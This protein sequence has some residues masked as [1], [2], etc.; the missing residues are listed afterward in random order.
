METC[1]ALTTLQDAG[2]ANV[3]IFFN[4]YRELESNYCTMLEKQLTA[5]HTQVSALHPFTS[6]METFFFASLYQGRV[7]DGILQY[8][9]YFEVCRQ[10]SIPRVVFHGDYVQ[11]PYPFAKHCE[12]YLRLRTLAREYGVEFCQ[13]NVVRCKCGTP[14]FI[15]K[16][17]ELTDDDVSFVLDVKQMRRANVKTEEMLHAMAGK[18]SHVHLSDETALCDCAVPGAGHYNFKKLFAQLQQMNFAG[19]MVVELYRGDFKNLQQLL[20]AACYLNQTYAA[21]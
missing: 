14:R 11:T 2:V 12:N 10:L 3:E 13:E 9:R 20:D 4:T 21:V 17:R 8:K 15:E 18:I 1:E 6:G 16:M 5:H 7:E 19:T